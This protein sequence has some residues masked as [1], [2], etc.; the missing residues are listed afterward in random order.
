[1][2]DRLTELLGEIRE[3]EKR[4]QE[5]MRRRQDELRYSISNGRVRFER[6]IAELHKRWATSSF[7]YVV[8]GSFLNLLTAPVIYALFIPTAALDLCLWLYQAVCFP[9]YTIP[10]VRRS[11]HFFLDRRYLQYLN[12]IERLNCDYCSYFTGLISYATEIGAR[13]EQ[14]WCPIKHAS[15][16]AARHSRSRYFADYGDAEQYRTRLE[17]IRRQFEDIS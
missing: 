12:Y 13:T 9:I 5:E 4:V 16:A 8:R 15:A 3:L 6:E 17:A 14:Y 7:F 10:K 2:N 11:D 1:M